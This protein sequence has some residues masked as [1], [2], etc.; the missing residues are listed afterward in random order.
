M[1]F[2]KFFKK[3]SINCSSIFILSLVG[4]IL[5]GFQVITKMAFQN[6]TRNFHFP[7]SEKFPFDKNFISPSDLLGVMFND[8]VLQTLHKNLRLQIF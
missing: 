3:P 8:K 4:I 2:L 7:E 6:I 5:F 1:I